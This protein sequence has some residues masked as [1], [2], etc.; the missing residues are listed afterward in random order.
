[1]TENMIRQICKTPPTE[2]YNRLSSQ[3]YS[4]I[5]SPNEYNLG[6]EM[7]RAM[8]LSIREKSPYV[9]MDIGKVV[10]LW[11]AYNDLLAETKSRQ[12]DTRRKQIGFRM[13]ERRSK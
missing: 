11:Q 2:R 5:V 9:L 4:T 3:L 1:M 13:K 10:G 7:I 6:A 12:E 8:E